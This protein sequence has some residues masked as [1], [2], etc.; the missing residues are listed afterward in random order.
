MLQQIVE[1]G[2]FVGGLFAEISVV[3][4]EDDGNGSGGLK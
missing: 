2:Q 4:N 3:S 1:E